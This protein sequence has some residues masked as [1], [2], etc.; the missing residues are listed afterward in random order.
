M[1]TYAENERLIFDLV[2]D[3][4]R[5]EYALWADARKMFRD[6]TDHYARTKQG[7]PERDRVNYLIEKCCDRINRRQGNHSRACF[8]ARQRLTQKQGQA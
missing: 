7:T 1:M 2:L 5:R 4:A 3:A 6:V 8:A